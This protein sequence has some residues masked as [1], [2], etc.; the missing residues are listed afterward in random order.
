VS[1]PSSGRPVRRGQA[2][3]SDRDLPVRPEAPGTADAPDTPAPVELARQALRAARRATSQAGSPG[4]STAPTPAPVLSGA[5]PDGRDPHPVREVV[6]EM[7]ATPAWRRG[8]AVGGLLARW[9]EVVGEQ[10]AAHTWPESLTDGVLV[11]RT[12]STAWATQVR[13]WTP[14]LLTRVTEAYADVAVE[15]VVVLGPDAPSWR[16]GARRVPGRGPRDTYG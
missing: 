10:L 11:V 6:G 16:R 1:R 7:V 14:M 9:G 8:L 13:L 3:P 2:E 4:R 12:D 5:H 15:R